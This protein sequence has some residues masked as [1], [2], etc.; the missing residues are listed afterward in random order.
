MMNFHLIRCWAEYRKKVQ[1]LPAFAFFL[2]TLFTQPV[3]SASNIVSGSVYGDAAT[4][5]TATAIASVEDGASNLLIA[6]N[7]TTSLSLGHT[8]EGSISITNGFNSLA[9]LATNA[10]VTAAGGAP[11]LRVE[12]GGTLSILGGSFSGANDN[13]PL[14]PSAQAGA[15]ISGT[16]QTTLDGT[17]ILGGSNFGIG[18]PALEISDGNLIVTGNSVLTGGPGNSAILAANSSIQIT[19]G[20]F[21]GGAGGATLDLTQS[22]ATI[23]GGT[24]NAQIDTPTFF[25]NDSD[26]FLNGGSVTNGGLLSFASAGTTNTIALHSGAFDSLVFSSGTNALQIFTAGS[27]LTGN[28]ELFQVGGTMQVSNLVTDA[29]QTVRLSSGASIDFSE[30]F[31]LSSGGVFWLDSKNEQASFTSLTIQSNATLNINEAT[32]FADYF[33][34]ESFSTNRLSIADTGNGLIDAQSALF[35]TNSSLIVN[36]T[37]GGLSGAETNAYALISANTGQLFAGASTNTAAA[38]ADSFKENVDI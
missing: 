25:L 4:V 32:I 33:E 9:I 14:N 19:N 35:K 21:S 18:A 30:A 5:A 12:G 27:N 22:S 36:I 34:A 20:T 3:Y 23:L 11:A 29:F 38:T 17:T 13:S 10:T 6:H 1:C 16:T 15:T 2:C 24:F 8:I 7:G 37:G 28:I 26:L 31:T